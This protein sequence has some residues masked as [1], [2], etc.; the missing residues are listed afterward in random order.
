[1]QRES[2]AEHGTANKDAG[3]LLVFVEIRSVKT[4][5]P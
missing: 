3:T 2:R 5:R 1:M 4:P